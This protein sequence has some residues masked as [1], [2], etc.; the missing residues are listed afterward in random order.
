M[1]KNHSPTQTGIQIHQ[2][3]PVIMAFVSH[4]RCSFIRL[5]PFNFE[6]PNFLFFSKKKKNKNFKMYMMQNLL[7]IV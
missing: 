6:K 5:Y 2:Q 3:N 4:L 1:F 7:V